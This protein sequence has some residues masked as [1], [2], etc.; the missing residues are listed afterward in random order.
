MNI[1]STLASE[2]PQPPAALTTTQPPPCRNMFILRLVVSTD[3]SRDRHKNE[4]TTFHSAALAAFMLCGLEDGRSPYST[5]LANASAKILANA[6]AG[7]S[8]TR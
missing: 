7:L 2:P 5:Y 8:P 1:S 4:V 3:S 6:S